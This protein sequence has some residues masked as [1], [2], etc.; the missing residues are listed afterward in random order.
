MWYFIGRVIQYTFVIGHKCAEASCSKLGPFLIVFRPRIGYLGKYWSWTISFAEILLERCTSLM[1]LCPHVQV[2]SKSLVLRRFATP[3]VAY[4]ILPRFV[5]W[6]QHMFAYFHT[7]GPRRHMALVW[8]CTY[9]YNYPT[10]IIVWQK[11]PLGKTEATWQVSV[12]N[13]ATK[14][15]SRCAAPCNLQLSVFNRKLPAIAKQVAKHHSVQSNN[16]HEYNI[17]LLRILALWRGKGH[18]LSQCD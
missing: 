3:Q 17:K 5:S 15:F 6:K 12:S 2:P 9:A 13:V 4:A 8:M 11:L 1:N 18:E 14:A 16:S 10:T 7:M